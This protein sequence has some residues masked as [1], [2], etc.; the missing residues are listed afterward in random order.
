LLGEVL[1]AAK[2]ALIGIVFNVFLGYF[3]YRSLPICSPGATS[4]TKRSYGASR[5][6]NNNANLFCNQPE[7][8]ATNDFYAMDSAAW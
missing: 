2:S 3:S 4:I 8:V 1:F 6:F 5:L 7:L